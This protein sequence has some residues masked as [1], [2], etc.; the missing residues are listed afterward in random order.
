MIGPKTRQAS[1]A[2]QDA[3]RRTSLE[4]RHRPRRLR[5]SAAI[6]TL[7]RE[8]RLSPDMLSLSALRAIGSGPAA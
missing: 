4:L 2:A 5:R 1:G 3:E 8:T 6:R 7:V